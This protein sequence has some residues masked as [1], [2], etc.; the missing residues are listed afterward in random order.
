MFCMNCGTKLPDK[1]KFCYKCGEKVVIEG[2]SDNIIETSDS[3][4][5]IASENSEKSVPINSSVAVKTD[6]T[7]V[8]AVAVSSQGTDNVKDEN[9]GTKNALETVKNQDGRDFTVL[10]NTI[11]FP[12]DTFRVCIFHRRYVE[13]AYKSADEAYEDFLAKFEKSKDDM[14]EIHNAF[15]TAIV[16]NCSDGIDHAFNDL[17]SK[18]IDTITKERF[19]S[20]LNDRIKNSE[21]YQ[22]ILQ[23]IDNI[24]EMKRQLAY[25][26]EANKANWVGGGFGLTGAIKGAINAKALN[27]ATDGLSSLGRTLTGNSYSSRLSR[28]SDAQVG[29]AKYYANG[30]YNIVCNFIKFDLPI[31][32]NKI[33]AERHIMPLASFYSSDALYNRRE[34]VKELLRT[35]KISKEKAI[36]KLCDSL[37]L[38]HNR[39]K[40]YEDLLD[41]DIEA[42]EGLSEIAQYDGHQ[43]IL[44]EKYLVKSKERIQTALVPYIGDKAKKFFWTRVAANQTDIIAI[45]TDITSDAPMDFGL[46]DKAVPEIDSIQLLDNTFNIDPVRIRSILSAFYNVK[47]EFIGVGKNAKVIINCDKPLPYEYED[48]ITFKNVNFDD[49][50][51][52]LIDSESQKLNK[53]ADDAI[54]NKSYD[55]AINYLEKMSLMGN[56]DATFRLANLYYEREEWEKALDYYCK[57]PQN[58]PDA[59]YKAATLKKEKLNSPSGYDDLM[60]IAASGY[61]AR[62]EEF[63]ASNDYANEIVQL[64]NAVKCNSDIAYLKLAEIYEEG[65]GTETNYQKAVGY[66]NKSISLGNQDAKTKL[67]DLYLRFGIG[68]E[69]GSYGAPD[70]ALA[71]Q[72]YNSAAEMGNVT[73]MIKMA[74]LCS[75]KSMPELF[76]YSVAMSWYKEASGRENTSQ[77]VRNLRLLGTVEERLSFVLSYYAN[78]YKGTYYYFRGNIDSGTIENAVKAYINNK[79]SIT[80]EKVLILY[81][82]TRSTFFGLGKKGFII[83]SGYK[84]ITSLPTCI[85]LY[86]INSLAFNGNDLIALP[87]NEVIL[88]YKKVDDRD[89]Q[90][91]S[92][93]NEEVLANKCPSDMAMI[94]C[95][96]CGSMI[97]QSSAFCYNCGT[98]LQKCPNC[99]AVMGGESVFCNQCG[100]RIC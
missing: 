87:S 68:Y 61:I 93:L 64:E 2:E 5:M 100:T 81:D 15:I 57:C 39:I 50:Y 47:L 99:N 37:P 75:N 90:F 6:N 63:K 8:E 60:K 3:S 41:L 48:F 29:S 24:E 38:T 66:Y 32:V 9:E 73:A 71:K 82:A 19:V 89:R 91:I 94:E 52:A 86:R 76:D 77:A 51:Q 96:N 11:H 21:V 23:G 7:E 49:A 65:R 74:D 45:I 30:V 78:Q 72:Y 55:Q 84:I 10:G 22:Q 25:E 58:N 36:K 34:N 83:T 31:D 54:N 17:I 16:T 46:D 88:S 59:V 98:R 12:E 13:L 27:I 4:K 42:Y 67:A 92:M 33:F 28:Y 69:N 18:E 62:A 14:T 97:E 20:L 26:K 40:F 85:S 70:Y 43:Y 53:L 79:Y 80:N 44:A 56:Y 1:A 35:F 95:P